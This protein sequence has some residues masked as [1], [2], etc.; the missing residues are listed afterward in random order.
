MD[1]SESQCLIQVL[2]VGTRLDENGRGVP[3]LGADYCMILQLVVTPTQDPASLSVHSLMCFYATTASRR[4]RHICLS[5]SKVCWK[6]IMKWPDFEADP[7]PLK[8]ILSCITTP[9]A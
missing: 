3:K 7:G 6:P 8:L 9:Y 4:C 2:T 1:Y 5:N